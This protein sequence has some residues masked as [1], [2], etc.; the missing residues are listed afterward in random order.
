MV[1][2]RGKGREGG[3]DMEVEKDY[4]E[5]REGD[6]ERMA[7]SRVDVRGMS[8]ESVKVRAREGRMK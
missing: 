8:A 7:L 6:G 2:Y 4:D 1:V 5:E 3:V